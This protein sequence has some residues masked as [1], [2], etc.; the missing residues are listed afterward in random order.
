[1][2]LG[3]AYEGKK[4]GKGGMLRPLTGHV[5]HALSPKVIRG[6]MARSCKRES[7]AQ[8]RLSLQESRAPESPPQ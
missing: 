8:F 1:M 5:T 2:K 4:G 3:L 6:H 7:G